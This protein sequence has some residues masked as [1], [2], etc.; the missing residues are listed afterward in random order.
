MEEWKLVQDGTAFTKIKQFA[1]HVADL[2]DAF[3]L[4]ML[5]KWGQELYHLA[6]SFDVSTVPAR[7]RQFPD[8]IEKI[9]SMTFDQPND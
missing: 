4:Y 9:A 3:S 6:E 5:E 8:I 7:I 1:S 2:D